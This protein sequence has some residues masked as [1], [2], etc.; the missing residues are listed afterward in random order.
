MKVHEAWSPE[1]SQLI[2][3]GN[4]AINTVRAAVD[5]VYEDPTLGETEVTSLIGLAAA[6]DNHITTGDTK[7]LV[8]K[9]HHIESDLVHRGLRILVRRPV[10]P[11]A[12]TLTDNYR[13]W[14]ASR[15]IGKIA[16]AT[17]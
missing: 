8:I 6:I 7:E 11:E 2:F 12:P 9:N 14:R 5:A 13:A 17:V 1:D 10:G 16:R 15:L 3:R 4:A